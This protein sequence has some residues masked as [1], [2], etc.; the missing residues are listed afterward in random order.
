[1]ICCQII[2]VILQIDCGIK[3]GRV[4]KL[5]PNL[6]NK[7]KY[8]LHYKNLQ[9]YLSLGIKLTNVHRILEFN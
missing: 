7:S 3:I 9:L 4:N 2:V 5:V 1:M 6:G 8:L